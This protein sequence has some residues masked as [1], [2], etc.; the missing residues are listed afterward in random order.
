MV[1]F[2]KEGDPQPVGVPAC[3]QVSKFFNGRLIEGSTIQKNSAAMCGKIEMHCIVA[4][5]YPI[6]THCADNFR[7][8]A[9]AWNWFNSNI[10]NGRNALTCICL[11]TKSEAITRAFIDSGLGPANNQAECPPKTAV[12]GGKN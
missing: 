5:V 10:K 9:T 4:K 7:T 6:G 1:D 12:A 8:S 11:E 3:V 2:Q